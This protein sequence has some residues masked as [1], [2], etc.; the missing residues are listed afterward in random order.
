MINTDH[1]ALL[2]IEPDDEQV[3]EVPVIDDITRRVTAAFNANRRSPSGY[4]GVHATGYGAS[5]DNFDHFVKLADGTE[6]TTNS[7]CI[8]YVAHCRAAVPAC[9]LAKIALLPDVYAE[10]TAADLWPTFI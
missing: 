8:H 1:D 7:L 9:E 10:P 2:M 6:L 4:R 5:S 3:T